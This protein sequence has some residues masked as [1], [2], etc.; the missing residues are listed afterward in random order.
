MTQAVLVILAIVIII[1]LLSRPAR[2]RLGPG[3]RRGKEKLVGICEVALESKSK[4]ESRKQ[5]VLA[6]FTKGELGNSEIR[7]ALGVSS[8]TAV[9]YLD[10]LES[11]GK[12]VQVGKV[13]RPSLIV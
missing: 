4:K 11:E 3:L 1:L 5:K 2:T 6:M 13:G 12:V 7:K 9:R 10:E 8:R